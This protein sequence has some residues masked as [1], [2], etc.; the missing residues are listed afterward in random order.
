MPDVNNMLQKVLQNAPMVLWGVDKKGVVTLYEGQQVSGF[1]AAADA[2][3]QSYKQAFVNSPALI[4][5]IEEAFNGEPA[6]LVIEN[7]TGVVEARLSPELDKKGHVIGVTGFAFDIT[8]RRL[9]EVELRAQK[10]LFENLV[11]IARATTERPTLE[12]TLQNALNVAA[13]MTGAEL[14]SLFLLN[15]EG[16]VLQS[17]VAR[18]RAEPKR[19]REIVNRVMTGGLAGWVVRNRRSVLIHDTT[20]DE[21]WKERPGNKFRARS[22]LSVPIL[23]GDLIIGVMTLTHPD[24]DRFTVDHLNLIQAAG[25]Q[26]ALALRNA[27]M[28]EEQ[29]KLADFQLTL[30][31]VLRNVGSYLDPESVSRVAVE[32]IYRLTNWPWVA[33]AIPDHADQRLVIQ[34]QA[35]DFSIGEGW[36]VQFGEGG[37]GEAYEAGETRYLPD[38]SNL[39]RR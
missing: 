22:S 32:E 35:G 16:E 34:A 17:I 14:G 2:V 23:F 13:E 33:I 37:M 19:K 5:A 18:G 24:P 25:D 12:A 30:Y 29:R 7:E 38:V 1:E 26:M 3:G 8:E 6:S 15:E 36:S 10:Q 39:P 20:K 21:R 31:E 27:Q 28:F 9:A 4:I 11:A